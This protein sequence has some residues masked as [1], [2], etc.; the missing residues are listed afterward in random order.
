MR[1]SLIVV[2]A[3][4][5]AAA[6]FAWLAVYQVDDAYIVYRY[7]DNLA[8]GKGFVFNAGERVEGVSCFLWTL[9]LAACA[10]AR[11]PPPAVAPVLT[12]I[13]GI[14]VLILMP[15]VSARLDG[16]RS[17]GR[18]DLVAPVLLAA[19]PAF[20]YWSVGALE[21][22]PYTLLLL[23]AL[24]DHLDE[25][26]SGRGRRS[27]L[28]I[29]LATL[30]RP[31]AP[32]LAAGLSVDRIAGLRGRR[33]V[34]RLRD[35][36]VWWGVVGAF[37]L[38]FLGFRRLYFGDWLPNTYYAKI[39]AGL[40]RNLEEGRRYTLSFATSLAPGFGSESFPAAAAGI[41]LLLVLLAHGLPRPRLRAAALLI[42][43][44]GLAVIVEGGDWMFLHRFYV[45]VLPPIMLLLVAAGSA[46]ASEAPRLRAAVA[47]F[48]ILLACSEVTSGV[49]ER[50]G[51]N[52]LAVNAAGY[53][54]AHHRIARYLGEHGR[55][56]DVVALMDVGI[57]GAGQLG[58]A[59]ARTA[60]RAG[61]SVVIANSR[62][63]E[64][65]A[66]VVSAL[67]EEVLKADLGTT[68]LR[69]VL[70]FKLGVTI[71]RARESVSAVRLGRREARELGCRPGV[72]AF[73]SERVSYDPSGAP[74]VFDRVFIPG[75]RFRITRELHY[76]QSERGATS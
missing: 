64:S 7:A 31:E 18:W 11:L 66:S 9:V 40:L 25:Q 60:L 10:A 16:R 5:A 13:A 61:R 35:T 73:E 12:G 3:L 75:D 63:P 24:R 55:P 47:G 48:G 74:V 23:L 57:I 69:Q 50:N 4:A 26:E 27:A 56:G 33:P 14:A 41:L 20:A 21:T 8:R 65:L 53:R 38:P 44:E 15:G 54:F 71:E 51:P 32:L 72:P 30:M 19:H 43:A 17:A 59:M 6:W 36:A 29:G 52:G 67:G 68:P 42:C 22:I 34:E 37:L 49:M 76:E 58:Q 2:L 39:G 62:G 1:R 45:P 46:L 70:E 28:W